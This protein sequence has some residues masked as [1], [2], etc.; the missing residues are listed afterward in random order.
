[1]TL[2]RVLGHGCTKQLRL[3]QSKHLTLGYHDDGCCRL[4][5]VVVAVVDVVVDKVYRE[6]CVGTRK[7]ALLDVYEVGGT[8]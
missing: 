8:V 6:G 5:V 4:V 1:M 2:Q 3:E 7:R